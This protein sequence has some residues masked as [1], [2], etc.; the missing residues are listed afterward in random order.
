MPWG[1]SEANE[2]T[3]LKGASK[4]FLQASK[5]GVAQTKP[6]YKRRSACGCCSGAAVMEFLNSFKMISVVSSCRQGQRTHR[7]LVDERFFYQTV[8]AASG[9]SM[10]HQAGYNPNTSQSCQMPLARFHKWYL[11]SSSD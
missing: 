9:A 6:V 1:S 7:L 2:G 4:S 10:L 11:K 8:S 3:S 5:T